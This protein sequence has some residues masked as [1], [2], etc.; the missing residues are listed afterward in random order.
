MGGGGSAIYLVFIATGLE[1][2]LGFTQKIFYFHVPSAW[3]TYLAFVVTGV[4]SIAFL[5][6]RLTWLDDLAHSSLEVGTVF[7]TLVLVTG[8]LWAKP[9]WGAYWVWDARLTTTLILWLIELA[10]L[11]LRSFVED[12][13][14]AAVSS[15][16]LAVLGLIDI[17]IIHQSVIRWRG[18]HPE[19][20]VVRSEGVGAG[21]PSEFLTALMVSLAAFTTLYV[22]LTWV[23]FGHRPCTRGS[24]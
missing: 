12:R 1:P 11:A 2:R 13:R 22:T 6:K 20:V 23:R 17:P 10:Y 15:A 16:V 3:V 19:P 9:T 8:P 18:L 7:T 21:L 4:S 24:G 5:F 14:K